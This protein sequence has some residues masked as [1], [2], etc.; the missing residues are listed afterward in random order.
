VISQKL[1]ARH[2]AVLTKWKAFDSVIA[3]RTERF[4]TAIAADD[5][6]VLIVIGTIHYLF[7][8]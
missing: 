3:R 7:S 8:P 1:D 6:H 4:A 2:D 5:R